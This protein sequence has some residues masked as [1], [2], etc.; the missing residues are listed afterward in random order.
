MAFYRHKPTGKLAS[1]T[2]G[3]P[4]LPHGPKVGVVW[5]GQFNTVGSFTPAEFR[6]EFEIV[7]EAD[8]TD[9]YDG[10]PLHT[11]TIGPSQ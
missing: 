10:A 8:A 9:D 2:G 3:A 4:R 11:D 5:H 7:V 6:A 1:L